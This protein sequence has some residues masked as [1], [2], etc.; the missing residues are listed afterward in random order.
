MSGNN[1]SQTLND[2]QKEAITTKENVSIIFAGPGNQNERKIKL[3]EKYFVG[4]GKT[5]VKYHFY[6]FLRSRL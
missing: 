3:I 2:N 1:S 4:T 5:T 6:Y